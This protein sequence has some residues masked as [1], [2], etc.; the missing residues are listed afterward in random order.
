MWSLRQALRARSGSAS[1]ERVIAGLPPYQVAFWPDGWELDAEAGVTVRDTHAMAEARRWYRLAERN[2]SQDDARRVM[3]LHGID[4]PR[5][6]VAMAGRRFPSER[7]VSVAVLLA[8][9][10][11][12]RQRRRRLQAA[13]PEALRARA[14]SWTGSRHDPALDPVAIGQLVEQLLSRGVAEGLIP[15]ARY[16]VRVHSGDGYGIPSHRCLVLVGLDSYERR[17]VAEVLKAALVPW[18]RGVVRDGHAVALIEPEVRAPKLTVPGSSR[19]PG[20]CVRVR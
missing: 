6:L 8:A 9:G 16:R 14:L 12:V 17:R 2:R 15:D 20:T 19:M 18:N 7:V 3:S 13:A 11:W 1:A 10:D 4:V 5:S